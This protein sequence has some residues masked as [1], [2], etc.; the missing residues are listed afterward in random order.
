MPRGKPRNSEADPQ[1]IRK[2]D[3][4]F[5]IA[6]SERSTGYGFYWNGRPCTVGVSTAPSTKR[7]IR[8]DVQLA[9]SLGTG[10]K[11]HNTHPMEEADG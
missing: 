8:V 7:P 6:L 2:R 10:D 1:T 9:P 4:L 11:A 5:Q 3:E